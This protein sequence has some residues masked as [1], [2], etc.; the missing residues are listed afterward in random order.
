M[1]TS[2]GELTRDTMLVQLT[3]PCGPQREGRS[4]QCFVRGD[5]VHLRYC[6]SVYGV[7]IRADRKRF[8]GGCPV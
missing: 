6:T 2:A 1:N 4:E 3:I 5:V 7:V 8:L